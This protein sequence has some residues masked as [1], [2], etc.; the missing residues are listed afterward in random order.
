ME[1]IQEVPEITEEIKTV[2][3]KKKSCKP[4]N[5]KYFNEY[6]HKNKDKI[7][8]QFCNALVC[9]LT[10]FRHVKGKKCLMVQKGERERPEENRIKQLL[11]IEEKMFRILDNYFETKKLENQN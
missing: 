2:V 1:E 5:P 11:T 9:R 4:K 10:V 7:V 6:Y 3:E 8:C